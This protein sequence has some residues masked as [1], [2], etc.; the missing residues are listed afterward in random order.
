[1]PLHRSQINL[2]TLI[3]QSNSQRREAQL[4]LKTK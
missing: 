3:K 1:M 4:K 2:K